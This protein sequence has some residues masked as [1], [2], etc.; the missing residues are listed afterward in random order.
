MPRQPADIR[1]IEALHRYH[2]QLM[3][4]HKLG[5]LPGNVKGMLRIRGKEIGLPLSTYYD[6]RRKLNSD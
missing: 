1:K 2:V 4:L 5:R 3:E 6:H